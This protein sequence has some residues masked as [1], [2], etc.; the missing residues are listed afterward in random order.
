MNECALLSKCPSYKALI[1][2]YHLFISGG[3][4]R[5]KTDILWSVQ[6]GGR[7]AGDGEGREHEAEGYGSGTESEDSQ[8]HRQ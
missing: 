6:I 5:F 2:S 3:H 4:G 1:T 7:A 8:L